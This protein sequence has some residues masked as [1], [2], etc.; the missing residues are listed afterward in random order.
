MTLSVD[1]FVGSIVD[2]RLGAHAILNASNP[3]LGLGS[4]VSGAIR[5]AC[6]PD[7]Q[8]EVRRRWAEELEEPLEA[9][10]CLVTGAGTATAF[11]WVLHVAAV[12]YMKREPETGGVSGPS[13]VRSC[14]RAALDEASELARANELEGALILG[15]PLLGASHGGLGEVVSLAAMMEA[16]AERLEGSA[17]ARIR[18]AVLDA[19]TARL[20]ASAAERYGVP[21]RE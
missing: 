16:I 3:A 10:D 19:R 14:M 18:F 6:G 20:V 8:A 11:R 12:D 5:D 15:A 13:R 1:A 17:I 9:E 21:L 7:F 4:G 2:P